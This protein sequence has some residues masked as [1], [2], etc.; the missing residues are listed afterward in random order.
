MSDELANMSQ[1]AGELLRY[2][3]DPHE[4]PYQNKRYAGLMEQLYTSPNFKLI[5][6]NVAQGLEIQVL[7]CTPHGVFLAGRERSPFAFKME[8]YKGSMRA[9]ERIVH[10]VFMLA[11]AAY[12]FPTI[13]VLDQDDEVLRP[14]MSV[15]QVV[16]FVRDMCKVCKGNNPEDPEHGGTEIQIAWQAITG[17]PDVILTPGGKL[18][19]GCLA[20]IARYAFDYLVDNGL[21]R[22]LSED[23]HGN[24]QPTPAYRIQVKQLAGNQT[25]KLI[26]SLRHLNVS[27]EEPI[28]NA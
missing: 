1:E 10:G 9:E 4:T 17:L 8:D 11:I 26:Q 22:R 7:A 18:A 23:N 21:M 24:Y 2:A 25:L 12:C 15:D 13:E 3:M 28:T 27:K 14:R 19:M 20:G 6:D 5:F 16:A